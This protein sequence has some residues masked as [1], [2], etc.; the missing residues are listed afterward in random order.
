VAGTGPTVPIENSPRLSDYWTGTTTTDCASRSRL[1]MAAAPASPGIGSA[2][3]KGTSRTPT[4][5][6]GQLTYGNTLTA[7]RQRVPDLGNSFSGRHGITSSKGPSP[8]AGH[9]ARHGGLQVAVP[10]HS[11]RGGAEGRHMMAGLAAAPG[12]D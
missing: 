7:L 3:R 12:G 5:A 10:R 6:S 4:H 1:F 9:A 8:N 11:A 2:F